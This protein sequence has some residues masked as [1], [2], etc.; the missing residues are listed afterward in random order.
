M[1]GPKIRD[2]R[3]ALGYSQERLASCLGVHA[4]TVSRW[5]RGCLHPTGEDLRL[6]HA[7]DRALLA[8]ASLP[9]RL[10]RIGADPIRE[11]TALLS[12]LHPDLAAEALV[13]RTDAMALLS[14]AAYVEGV[15][16]D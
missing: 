3:V 1:D 6:L 2:L 10:R 8:D 15:S 7:F 12:T 16:L 5:E 11:L 14:R 9:L 4:L 13:H